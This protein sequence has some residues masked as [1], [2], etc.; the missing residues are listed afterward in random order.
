MMPTNPAPIILASQ[1]AARSAMLAA[2]GVAHSIA[3]AHVDE[4]ALTAGLLA[5][6]QTA[7]NICDALAEAKAIK[8]SRRS[9]GAIII[10]AD[11]VGA[12]ADGSLIG[13]PESPEQLADRLAHMSGTSHRLFTA[14]VLA[15]GGIPIWRHI[16]V[17][18]LH[19]RALSAHYIQD[20]VARYWDDVRHC[21]GGY[22]FEAEG[23]QLFS[24]IDGSHFSVLGLPLLPVLAQLRVLGVLPL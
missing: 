4:A 16:D 13:K 1:S 9:P 3:P 17:V 7:R 14:V 8:L 11:Q 10:G 15:Q 21:A 12:M 24:S 2:A 19:V 20:Y 6:G 23:A 22:R 5:E 18:T